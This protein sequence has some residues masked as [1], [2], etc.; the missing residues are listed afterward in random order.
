MWAYIMK[1]NIGADDDDR[2]L[3]EGEVSEKFGVGL[4]HLREWRHGDTGE[5]PPVTRIGRRVF[6]RQ[7][8]VRT[9][10]RDRE[11]GE[12]RGEVRD[13]SPH[14]FAVALSRRMKPVLQ[15]V[16]YASHPAPDHDRA[17]LAIV[18]FPSVALGLGSGLVDLSRY[19]AAVDSLARRHAGVLVAGPGHDWQGVFEDLASFPDFLPMPPSWVTM[20]RADKLVTVAGAPANGAVLLSGNALAGELCEAAK[21]HGLAFRVEDDCGDWQPA[22]GIA[23]RLVK[24]VT[25]QRDGSSA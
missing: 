7:G 13:F 6:Y 5:G 3:S 24:D 4:F 16:F 17:T 9:W 23:G 21:A 20:Y 11:R 10:L 25:A 2:L 14:T 18:P 22:G 12:D 15:S 1:Q 8:G 19:T